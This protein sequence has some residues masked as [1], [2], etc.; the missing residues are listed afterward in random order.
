MRYLVFALAVL[1][2]VVPFFTSFDGFDPG[3]YPV[4]QEDPAIQPAGW[5]FSIWGVIYLALIV[6]AG[7]G[8][9]RGDAPGW[10][11][12]RVPLAISL[13]VGAAWLPVAQVSPVWATILIWVMLA[14]ALRAL[15]LG[16]AAREPWTLDLPLGLYAGWLSAASFVSIALLLAGYGVVFDD[17]GWA[18]IVLPLAI[19]FAGLML[20]RM[21]FVPGYGVAVAWALFGIVMKSWGVHWTVV[22]IAA[23]GIALVGGVLLAT[24]RRKSA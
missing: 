20:W 24:T 2:A 21:G 9:V 8:I 19:A 10:R 5:A 18:R 3:L 15:F 12:S 14:T 11:E 16:R 23:A 6:H 7:F 1:F 22:V 17:V 13:A 4:P